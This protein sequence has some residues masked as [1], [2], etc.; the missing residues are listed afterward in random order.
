MKLPE[1]KRLKHR[2]LIPQD[3]E[4]IF[5]LNQDQDVIKLT[6]DPPFESVEHAR[7]FLNHYDHY[8]KFG[9]GRWAVIRRSDDTFLGWCG[10]KYSTKLK[11]YDIG[12]RFFK[13]YW[14]QGYATESARACMEYG[15]EQLRISEIVGRAMLE[16][17]ASI[18]VLEKL[19]MTYWRPMDFEGHPGVVYHKSA[20]ETPG[21]RPYGF[22]K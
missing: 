8:D 5:L 14:N 11:E 2:E 20:D 17:K 15:F 7:S 12:F 22:L 9:F 10:I 18:R 16:N 21:T 19:G 6:G 1:T 13:K 4:Q 3:A